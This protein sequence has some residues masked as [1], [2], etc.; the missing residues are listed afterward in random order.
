[1]VIISENFGILHGVDTGD[2]LTLTSPRGP[3][4]LHVLGK[5]VDYSWNHGSLV[6]NR[7]FYLDHWD[8][9]RVDAFDV[10]L[11]PGA[12]GAAVKDEIERRYK[13]E[14]RLWVMSRGELQGHIDGMIE[15]LYGIAFGQQLVVMVVA[16]LGVVMALLISVLQRKRELGLLRAIGASRWRV[17]RCV[18]AEA[19]RR[20]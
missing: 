20:G 12:D 15:R 2:T 16:A 17:V 7:Q 5:L 19:S 6:I 14:H 9:A 3:V 1:A 18:V 8:D 13:I 10:Y 11:K 4:R